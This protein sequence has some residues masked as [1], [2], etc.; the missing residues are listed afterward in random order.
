MKQ[1]GKV[2]LDRS[3][4]FFRFHAAASNRQVL[5]NPLATQIYKEWNLTDTQWGA[6]STAALI[7]GSICYPLWGYLYDRFSRGKLLSLAAF[8]WGGT[9]WLSAIAPNYQ[10][11]LA[12]RASTGIDD[13]SYPGLYSLIAD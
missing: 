1:A 9:T 10:L 8:I 7:V 12:S 6:I 5:I 2:S 13:S 11:F 3:H 4:H